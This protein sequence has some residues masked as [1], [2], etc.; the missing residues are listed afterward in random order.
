MT[1]KKEKRNKNK[2]IVHCHCNTYN[3]ISS[4]VSRASGVTQ[5]CLQPFTLTVNEPRVLQVCHFCC[6]VFLFISISLEVLGFVVVLFLWYWGLNP[7]LKNTRQVYYYH[8]AISPKLKFYFW[9]R[10]SLN[11]SSWPWICNLPE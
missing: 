3:S 2:F 7:G 11:C 10:T 6:L 1:Q 5:S 9:N 8:W 4:V